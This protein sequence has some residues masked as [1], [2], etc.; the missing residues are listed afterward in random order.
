MKESQFLSL[1]KNKFLSYREKLIVDIGDDCA[2]A[3]C[4]GEG[5]FA[6]DQVIDGVHFDDFMSANLVG[7]KLLARNL[8]DLASMGQVTPNYALLNIAS[9]KSSEYLLEFADGIC[10]LAEKYQLAI[11]G[12]DYAVIDDSGQSVFSL[13]IIGKLNGLAITRSG[14]EIGDYLFVSGQ[15][16]NSFLSQHH[17]NFEPE[18]ELGAYLAENSFV[19]AMIDLSDGLAKDCL[20]LLEYNNSLAIK[21]YTN[22]LPLRKGATL[23]QAFEQGEDYGLCFVVS[24]RNKNFLEKQNKFPITCIGEFISREGSLFCDENNKF[25]KIKGFEYI[26]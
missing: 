26:L 3:S 20:S 14:A 23:N 4:Q 15:L 19:K 17:L 21:F 6:S 25:L 13:T 8:S 5:V 1:L 2:V 11:I 24:K 10:S 22:S 12:G 16:G 7:R 9:N 18:M